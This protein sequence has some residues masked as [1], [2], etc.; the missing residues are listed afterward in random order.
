MLQ[1]PAASVLMMNL[2][3]SSNAYMKKE[4]LSDKVYSLCSCCGVTLE[5]VIAE[6]GR[7]AVFTLNY[8]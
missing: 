7:K 6:L 1:A 2:T 5:F 8:S 3:A 4:T